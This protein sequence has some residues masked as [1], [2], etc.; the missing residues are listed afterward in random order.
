MIGELVNVLTEDKVYLDGLF[1]ASEHAP[2]TDIDAAIL[3][4]GLSGNFYKSRLLKHFANVLNSIGISTVLIN[5][6]GHDYLNSTQRMGRASTLGAAVEIIDECKHDLFAWCEFLKSRQRDQLMLLGHSL[7]GIKSL[8]AQA[9]LPHENVKRVAALSST[10]LS[11][12]SLMGSSGGDKFA[13][14]LNR[15]QMMV[16]EGKG[17]EWM[18]VTFPF[19]TWMSAI[20]YL[21]K[22][23]D[24]DKNN[25]MNFMNQISIPVFA[26]F[27]QRELEHNPAF[28]AMKQD[29]ANVDQPNFT[30]DIVPNAD[31]FYSAC[32]DEASNRLLNWLKI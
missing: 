6:R 32:F 30:I 7:G 23:G 21:A 25:W 29:L 11:Y 31:H 20:A 28:S 12:D 16:A 13:Y 17:E 5:T 14:W 9:H 8:Y 22:Y 1:T 3:V 2:S 4:H 24:G 27:G 15:A 10:K 26:A 18:F 19:A